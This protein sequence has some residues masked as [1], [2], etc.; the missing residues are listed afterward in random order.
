MNETF[1]GGVVQPIQLTDELRSTYIALCAVNAVLSIVGT[2]ANV[3]II[4]A[5][6][7]TSSVGSPSLV[8][9]ITL[10]V[11]DLGVGLV[12]QPLYIAARVAELSSSSDNYCSLSIAYRVAVVC[13]S[14]LSFLIMT[15]IS[16]DRF[17]AICLCMEYRAKVTRKRTI[18]AVILLVTVAAIWAITVVFSPTT[19]YYLSLFLMPFCILITSLNYLNIHRMLKQQQRQLRKLEHIDMEQRESQRQTLYIDRYKAILNTMMFI[20]AAFLLCY[21]PYLCYLFAVSSLGQTLGT[22]RA[23][24]VTATIIFL[25]SC[26]NPALYFWRIPEIRQTVKHIIHWNNNGIVL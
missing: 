14:G 12:A 1:C 7:R 18:A 3:A 5:I 4:L 13:L 21:L 20:Y 15:A 26:L 19:P 6:R 9:I 17:L 24:H 8:L 23:R 2:I 11:S 22:L 10:A 25:N 16:F